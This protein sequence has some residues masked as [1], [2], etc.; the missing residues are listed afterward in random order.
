[1]QSQK[2]EIQITG[3]Q[4]YKFNQSSPIIQKLPIIYLLNMNYRWIWFMG[5]IYV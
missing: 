1:M 4:K 3:T 5:E 2:C